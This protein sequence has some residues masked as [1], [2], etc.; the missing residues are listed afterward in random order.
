M[1]V[2]RDCYKAVVPGGKSGYNAGL[3]LTLIIKIA[4]YDDYTYVT[5]IYCDR[6]VIS[7]SVG[8][9]FKFWL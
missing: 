5:D 3:S 4:G 6:R 1:I 8:A 7:V 2:P 9:S